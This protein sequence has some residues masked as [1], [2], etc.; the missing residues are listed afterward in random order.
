VRRTSFAGMHCSIAQTL[1][2]V[3][4][5]WTPLILRD[6]YMGLHRFEDLA[7]NLKIS[8]NL[9]T[10]DSTT[11]STRGVLERAASTRPAGPAQLP[12]DRGPAPSSCPALLVLMAWGEPAGPRRRAGRRAPGATA[13]AAHSSPRR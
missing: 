9:L 8:R 12:P 3:G 7:E 10:R 1:D 4:E 5:G 2:V 11:S 6:V 13:P